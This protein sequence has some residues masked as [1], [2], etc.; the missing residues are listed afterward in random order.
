VTKRALE[1]HVL[2]IVL[3]A[4]VTATLAAQGREAV[5]WNLSFQLT[6]RDNRDIIDLAAELGIRAPARV[7][8]AGSR[9]PLVWVRVA[10]P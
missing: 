10:R 5:V 4:I 3:S 2:T 6:A 7:V 8:A 1:R 9:C